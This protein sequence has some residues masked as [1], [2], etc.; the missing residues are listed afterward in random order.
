[1]KKVLNL[2]IGLGVVLTTLAGVGHREQSEQGG[3]FSN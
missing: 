2:K 3:Q 1:M